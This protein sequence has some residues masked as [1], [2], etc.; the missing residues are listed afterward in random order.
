MPI[1]IDGQKFEDEF[2]YAA[3]QMAEP[4][5][6]QAPITSPE[7]DLSGIPRITV[8]SKPKAEDQSSKREDD[9]P[10]AQEV[11]L[12][13]GGEKLRTAF[14]RLTGAGGEERVETWPERAIRGFLSGVMLPGDVASGVTDPSSGEAFNRAMEL[15]LGVVG[16]PAPIANKVVD[17]T[18]GSIAGISAKTA[19]KDLLDLAKVL[20]KRGYPTDE[21]FQ[22]AGW[23]KGFDGQWKFEIPSQEAK[24]RPPPLDKESVKLNKQSTGY[25]FKYKDTTLDKVLDFP[26]LYKAYPDLKNLQIKHE[27]FENAYA[28]YSA[29]GPDHYIGLGDTFFKQPHATQKEIMLHEIQHYIQR[30]EAFETARGGV[31]AQAQELANFIREHVSLVAQTDPKRAEQIAKNYLQVIKEIKEKYKTDIGRFLYSR[32]PAEH[33]A[34]IVMQ[35]NRLPK[36]YLE[37]NDPKTYT[38]EFEKVNEAPAFRFP[39]EKPNSPMPPE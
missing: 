22:T 1:A 5:N 17:G 33:E 7:E 38:R 19:D 10:K 13:Y 9:A 25:D 39:Y 12:S 31:Q 4:A 37:W 34:N 18:L 30:E 26:E 15:S 35:R 20:D 23:Y 27:N 16:G 24:F 28:F 8:T 2:Q 11:P 6:S 3:S 36:E 21:I 29:G 14:R 32:D